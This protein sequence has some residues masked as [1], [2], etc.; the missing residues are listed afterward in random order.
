[1]KPLTTPEIRARFPALD[2]RHAGRAV[3]Y[4]DAPGGTQVPRAVADAVR[5]YLLRHSANTHWRY[6]TSVETDAIIAA[7]RLALADFLGGAPEEIAFGPNMTALTFH[8]SRALARRWE[9]GDEVVVTDLDHHADID[10]WREA[11]AERGATV[12]AVPFDPATGELEPD[13]LRAALGPRTRLV[14]IGAASNALGTITD[15]KRAAALAHDAGALCFVDAVHLAA[16]ER[17]DVA[18]IGCDFLACSPYKFYGPHLGVLWGRLPLVEALDVPRVA[19]APN[20][21]AERLETGTQAHES[22]AGATAAVDFLASVAGAGA[23]EA[24]RRRRLDAAFATL[25]ARGEALLRRLWQGLESIEGVTLF[26]PPPERP[27]TPTVSFVVSGIPAADVAARLAEL[28]LFLSHGDFY[29]ATVVRRL[30]H[31][32]DGVVRAGCACYTTEAEV[33]RLVEGVRGLR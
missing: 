29:A 21:T 30:G 26:P 23:G 32:A 12:R 13:A 6:P 1:M 25:H 19:P 15:V 17:I 22:I 31:E 8:L 4:F 9:P 16:H 3:A 10:P 11:A 24:D 33:D 7:G 14:A 5:D 27:R 2:R 28:A 18:S 20:R